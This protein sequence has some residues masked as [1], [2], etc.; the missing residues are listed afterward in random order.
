MSEMIFSMARI[1]GFSFSSRSYSFVYSPQGDG[2]REKHNQP[3]VHVYYKRQR[4]HLFPYCHLL[5]FLSLPI[6]S[7]YVQ[8]IVLIFVRLRL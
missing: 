8:S 2:Q 3:H 7:L 1:K 6:L 5:I 4:L